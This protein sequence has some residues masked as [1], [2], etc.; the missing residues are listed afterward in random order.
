MLPSGGEDLWKCVDKR[1]S[2][3]VRGTRGFLGSEKIAPRQAHHERR[4]GSDGL[5]TKDGADTTP[6]SHITVRPEPVEGAP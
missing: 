3:E 1:I 4:D 2:K 6:R 5:D